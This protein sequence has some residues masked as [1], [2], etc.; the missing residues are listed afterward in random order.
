MHFFHALSPAHSFIRY[1]ILLFFFSFFCSCIILEAV[2]SCTFADFHRNFRWKY[3]LNYPNRVWDTAKRNAIPKE[4]VH[5]DFFFPFF[6]FRCS[7]CNS[8]HNMFFFVCVHSCW[9]LI[10]YVHRHSMLCS[11]EFK[12]HGESE[13]K[14][15]KLHYK[16]CVCVRFF[17][18]GFFVHFISCVFSI[19]CTLV[20]LCYFVGLMRCWLRNC[21]V[22][23]CC[24]EVQERRTNKTKEQKKHSTH[25][26]M[27]IEHFNWN[28][29]FQEGRNAT[30]QQY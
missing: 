3:T 8:Q 18:S 25:T 14:A 26:H 2:V 20:I 13:K 9:C 1:G 19:F 21:F 5:R 23:N 28:A 11:L 17:L 16:V 24:F 12:Y 7:C 27:H 30:A 6:L 15:Q 4:K 10:L 29:E 22:S